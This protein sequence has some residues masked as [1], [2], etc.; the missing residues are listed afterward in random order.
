MLKKSEC[1]PSP[2]DRFKE[3]AY[4]GHEKTPVMLSLNFISNLDS[5]LNF[6]QHHRQ[7]ATQIWNDFHI[8]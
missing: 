2:N 7:T 8:T 5:L 1:C 6:T 3:N 4:M